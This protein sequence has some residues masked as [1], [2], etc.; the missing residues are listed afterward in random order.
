M[1]KTL[2]ADRSMLKVSMALLIALFIGLMIGVSDGIGAPPNSAVR[3]DGDSLR[4]CTVV[5]AGNEKTQEAVIL[6][7]MRSQVGQ[8]YDS[9]LVLADQKRIENLLLFNRV[10]IMPIP[11]DEGMSLLVLVVERLYFFPAPVLFANEHDV[12]KLSYG[13][14]L[15]HQN[16]FGRAISLNAAGW[17]G[18]NPGGQLQLRHPWI[19]GSNNLFAQIEV[20]W[21]KRETHILI[22]DRFDETHRGVVMA[23]GKRWGHHF[24]SSVQAGYRT[25]EFPAE[26]DRSI[27]GGDTVEKLPSVG[28]SLRYDGR[29]RLTYPKSGFYLEGYG[30]KIIGNMDVKSIQCGTD[31]RIYL[32]L[33]AGVSVAMRGAADFL[34]G[35]QP[36]FLWQSIGFDERVRGRFEQCAAADSRLLGSVEL[37][38]PILPIR[39]ISLP[40]D[41]LLALFAQEMPIGLSAGIFYDG[42]ALWQNQ[43]P[44]QKAEWLDGWGIGLHFHLPYIHLLRFEAAWNS[45]QGKP[46]YLLDL[47]VWF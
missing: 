22:T 3:A 25:I 42:A 23:M 14:A 43:S 26:Y 39:Y 31:G 29:D 35:D 21:K 1:K 36:Q 2:P 34:L 18:Y 37:R 12:E 33:G 46:E 44:L 16:L 47:S 45:R 7:E 40:P 10:E 30:Q 27:I 9:R 13:L 19:G 17:G 15:I 11:T 28:V 8:I 4:I 41:D 6:R 20:F 5:V 32:P 38:L 24:Y